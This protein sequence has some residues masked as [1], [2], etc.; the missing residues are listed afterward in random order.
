[1]GCE[2][3]SSGAARRHW[4]AAVNVTREKLREHTQGAFQVS[5]QGRTTDDIT[6]HCAVLNTHKQVSKQERHQASP[7][8]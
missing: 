3:T 7:V 8:P 2:A 1:M 5:T 4:S 6:M